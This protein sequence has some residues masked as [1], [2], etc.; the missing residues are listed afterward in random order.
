MSNNDLTL[1]LLQVGVIL[2]A[3]VVLGRIGRA[4]KLPA[5]VAELLGGLVLGPTLL[6]TFAPALHQ[7]LF[8][9]DAAA[10]LAREGITQLGLVLF[11]FLAGLEVDIGILRRERKA[12][13]WS[14]TFGIVVPFSVGFA[15]VMLLP[16]LWRAPSD[17][18]LLFLALMVATQLSISALP[19]IARILTDL[20]LLKTRMGAIVIGAATI[21]DLIGWALFAILL[22]AAGTA[23]PAAG[24][25]VVTVSLVLGLFA[26]ILSIGTAAGRSAMHWIRTRVGGSNSY[27]RLTLMVLVLCAAASEMIGTHAVFGAFLAGIAVSRAASARTQVLEAIRR[28]TIDV[29]VPLYFVSIGLRANFAAHFDVILVLFVLA[30]ATIGKVGGVALGATLGGKPRREAFAIA[31]AMNARGAMGVI[32][33]SIA[34]EH[35]LIDERVFV[36]LITMAVT[37]SMLGASVI[38]RIL[39]GEVALAEG[40]MR[41]A[42]AAANSLA[43]AGS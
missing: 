21:D 25:L 17:S 10:S 13:M 42:P 31:F 8:P 24:N 27:V 39:G 4:L 35:R 30:V 36:A 18:A 28:V 14:S 11:L 20:D 7:W 23:A 26:L 29:F 32:L 41:P 16:A 33:S 1:L 2:G 6:G 3:T 37:T 38:R 22:R 40:E 19:V 5:L 43:H 12:V 15:S 9:P 34:L